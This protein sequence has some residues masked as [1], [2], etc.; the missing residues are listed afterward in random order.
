MPA[1][2]AAIFWGILR[3]AVKA[4]QQQNALSVDG[5]VGENTWN[6]LFNDPD[7]CRG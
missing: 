5:I 6:A 2:S 4:F 1:T 7:A 3:N